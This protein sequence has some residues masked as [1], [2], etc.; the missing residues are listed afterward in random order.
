MPNSRL[1]FL[2]NAFIEQ[3]CSIE[4][5]KELMQLIADSNNE[6][7]LIELLDELITNVSEEARVNQ[8]SS[9]LILRRIIED[10]KKANGVPHKFS[11]YSR[12]AAAVVILI[13]SGL[14][15][16]FIIKP[17]S[18]KQIHNSLHT[19][20]EI[21]KIVPGGKHAI[22]TMGDGSQIVLDS[23]QNENIQ[24]ANVRISKKGGVLVYDV[25]NTSKSHG[26]ADVYNTLVTPAGGE[27]KV[28]LSDGTTVW[29]NASS[30]LHFPT[31]F[32]G[33]E[34]NV[35][36]TGEAYFEVA[37]NKKKPFIVNVRGIHVEVLGTHFNVNGYDDECVVKTS[38]LEGSVKIR[39]GNISAFLKP[40]Q[41]GVVGQN[42]RKVKIKIADMNQVIAWKEGLFQFDGANTK[43]IMRQIARWYDVKVEY[44]GKIPN[45]R[46]EGK[47][48]R[49]AQ[50]SDVLK[51]LEFSNIKFSIEGKKIIVK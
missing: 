38:L 15:Y 17:N 18:F 30:S 13:I 48:S 11:S 9:T 36:L 8:R 1:E 34:R 46:F 50:L 21:S 35:D 2:F 5:E 31:A 7:E 51:I 42:S 4:E 33:K 24:G 26:A 12:A 25:S 29:L 45:R 16:W 23:L 32:T 27:Y 14:S 43:E 47:I 37:K 20:K 10:S 6:N 41:Q 19:S 3:N 44:D 39:K 22:L 49:N 40:G 28:V